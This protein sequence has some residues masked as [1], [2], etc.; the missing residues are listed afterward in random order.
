M[1]EVFGDTS[2]IQYL[3]QTACLHLLPALY[4]KVVVA[5]AVADEIAVGRGLGVALPDLQGLAWV[6]IRE[7]A[8]RQPLRFSPDLDLGEKETLAL[9]LESRD[10]LVI[11]DDGLARRPAKLLELPF[12]GTIGVLLKAKQQAL[13]PRIEPILDQLARLGFRLDPVTRKAALE[14][15]VE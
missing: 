4:S 13:L 6:E 11:L 10:P 8:N 14:L 15:A 1:P 7:V 9:A 5:R 2:P 3:H 12:T